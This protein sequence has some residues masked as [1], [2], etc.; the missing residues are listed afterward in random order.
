MLE[1]VPAQPN[2]HKTELDFHENRWEKKAE[3]YRGSLMRRILNRNRTMTAE[4]FMYQ[5]AVSDNVDFDKRQHEE[6]EKWQQ[7]LKVVIDHLKEKKRNPENPDIR[8]LLL[9]L[10]GGM[11]G[12]YSAGQVVGLNEIG[13]TADVFSTIVGISAGAGTAAYYAAGPEQTRKGTSLFYEECVT[14]SFI[15]KARL[16]KVMDVGWLTGTAMGTG[17]KKLDE[18]AVRRCP[19]Q[20]FFG[21][22]RVSENGDY[23]PDFIDA[24]TAQPGLLPA[25]RASMSVPLVAGEVPPVNGVRYI[26]GAFDPL[27][28]EEVI[29]RFNPTDILVLP[30]T[31]FDRLD[32]FRLSPTE[33]MVAELAGSLGKAGS[34]N[35]LGQL[36][37]FMQIKEELRKSLETIEST[38]RVNVG[39][40]WPPESGLDALRQ[41]GGDIKAAVYESARAVFDDFGVPQ[42][43]EVPLYEHQKLAA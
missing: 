3:E 36:E 32:A 43:E 22:T 14:K 10:G 24:K 1:S 15:D 11:K 8:P 20:L 27:P 9:I 38:K 18:D 34:L 29:E 25:M 7:H 16:T 40:M 28:I 33:L 19:A 13:M 35:S 37:K 17:E 31:P 2:N 26:D 6:F 23:S 4:D 30:N 5:E 12:P 21:V 39:I 42:P 41:N